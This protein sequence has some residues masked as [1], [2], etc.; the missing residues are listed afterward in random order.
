MA[1]HQNNRGQTSQYTMVTWNVRGMAAP[2]KRRRVLAYLK[3]HGVQI[4]FLQETHMSP[5]GIKS[6]CRTW[7]GQ[8]FGTNVSTFARGVLIWLARGVPFVSSTSKIDPDGRYVV[9]EGCLDGEPLTLVAVYAPNSGH[10]VFFEALSPR[11]VSDPNTP[12][13][14]GGDFNCVPDIGMDRSSPP[15]PGAAC[16]K[17]TQCLQAWMTHMR[18]FDVWR[19]QHPLHREYSFYSPVHGLYTRLD[20]IMCGTL[21]VPRLAEAEYLASTQSDHCPLKVRLS[22]GRNRPSIPT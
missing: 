14:W 11:L 3:R 1:G 17:A 16:W 22:W 18:L 15:I 9:V 19:L 2:S 8:V 5:E 4:A 21:L 13:I 20:L 10:V 6:L 12:M 7:P